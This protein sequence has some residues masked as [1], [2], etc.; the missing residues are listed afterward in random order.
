[1][2]TRRLIIMLCL[3]F[4]FLLTESSGAGQKRLAPLPVKEALKILNLSMF[5]P[6]DVSSDGQLVAY[7]LQDAN[8]K[9]QTK[10]PRS[11]QDLEALGIPS[12]ADYC[13]IW[14]TNTVT[15]ISRN[16]TQGQ[17]TS[18]APVWSPNG[19][20]LAFYSDRDGLPTLWLWERA[21]G[22]V[23][24]ASNAI[25]R[26]RTETSIP[27]WTPDSKKLVI[28]VLPKGMSIDV[29]LRNKSEINSSSHAL[30]EPGSTMVLFSS[31][32]NPTKNE[33]P[34]NNFAAWADLAVV[35]LETKETKHITSRGVTDGYWLSPDGTNVA[36]LN[37]KRRVSQSNLQALFDLLVVSLVDGRS[38]TL[39]T[40]FGT[41]LLIPVSWSPDGKFLAYMTAG[42]TAKN[43]CWIVPL[44]GGEPRNVTPGE[45]PR[46]DSTFLYRGPLW[47]AAGENIYLL[48][49][50]AVWRTAIAEPR[51]EQIATIPGRTLRHIISQNGRT[52]WTPK[53]DAIIVVTRA[54]QNRQ[55]GFYEINLSTGKHEK[56]LEENKSYGFVPP[57]R[58]AVSADQQRLIYTS[59]SADEPEDIWT[60][61]AGQF[62]PKRVTHINPVFDRYVMGEGRLIEWK[63]LN[64][65]LV[66]GALLLPAGYTPGNR[67]PL[68]VYQYPGSMWST[69]GNLFGFN[70]FSSAVENWQFFATRGYA[71]L[72]ADVP[73]RPETYMRDIAA[74]IM[75]AVDKVIGLGICDPERVGITG[76]SN[77][78][79]GV[80]SLIVQTNRF[81]AAV[82]RMGPGNLI[83]QYTQMSETGASIYIAEMVQRTGGSLWEKRDKFIENS[84][85]FYFDKVETPL[86]IIQGTADRQ[87]M[88]ARSDEVFVSLRF[89]GKEVEYARYVG[90]SHGVSDWSFANQVDYLNRVIA[91]F[92]RWLKH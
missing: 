73:T 11:A 37:F 35:D 47:D 40:D 33:K 30:K 64:G 75:P 82:D 52:I 12:R 4:L 5:T 74:A 66:H 22:T 49:S 89:L 54:E 86:L 14:I 71:V 45:H 41:D 19:K 61:A 56:L 55:E 68:I 78:G 6:L 39:V 13:D 25:V 53:A 70:P 2:S 65:Q 87:V 10:T 34:N 7:V 44:A 32:A 18:W 24:K 8:R 3:A 26:T 42:S 17:G 67:Y 72:L 29:A 16:L 77:G 15:G 57:L 31:T 63:T 85:I 9:A 23:R 36:V 43:D 81:K 21:S 38:R 90:E 1:M 28:Q 84:P 69:H 91:W 83:S 58:I 27:R 92:D 80:L 48:S 50:T 79:Y 46:F 60:T 88:A 76:Q 20:Y 59:Q 51:A 62:R